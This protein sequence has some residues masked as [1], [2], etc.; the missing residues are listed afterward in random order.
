[1]FL[2]NKV[3]IK[4]FKE[5]IINLYEL[6]YNKK[7]V[8]TLNFPSK[9]KLKLNYI[10]SNNKK[11]LSL[12]I[13][14]AKEKKIYKKKDNIFG[15]FNEKLGENNIFGEIDSEEGEDDSMSIKN[16]ESESIDDEEDDY[17]FLKY[18]KPKKMKKSKSL[19]NKKITN[20]QINNIMNNNKKLNDIKNSVNINNIK[21][22]KND[23]NK[24]KEIN[25]DDLTEKEKI[26]IIHRMNTVY[27]K[28]S[29]NN[30][31]INNIYTINEN[32]IEP[33]EIILKSSKIDFTKD[34]NKNTN[35]FCNGFLLVS[36]PYNNGKI[37]ENSKNY[38]SI[39]G[40]LICSKLPA[41]ESIIIY[42][43]PLEDSKNLE[44]NNFC[45]SIC[46][47][48]GIKVC[49]N[50][51]RRSTYKSFCTNIVN[52]KGEKYYMTVYHFYHKMDTLTYNKK[53]SDNSLKNYLRKFGD[54]IYHTKEEKE[55]LEKDLEECQE[56]GFREFVYI[57]YAFALISK[58]PY[59]NQMKDILNNI[60]R[61]FTNYE[62]ILNQINIENTILNDLISY[63]IYGIPIPIPNS[64]ILFNMPF[65]SKKIRIESPYN[66]NIRNIQE[67]NY[68]NLLKYFS[69]ENILIIYR[70]MLFE[71]KILFIDKDYNRLCSIIQCFIDL[72]YPIEWV[73]TLIPMMS[74]QM[75]RYLQTFLPFING[76]SEDLLNNNALNALKEAEEG[77]YEIFIIKG[78]IELSKDNEDIY[79]GIPKLPEEV[80][81]KLYKELCDLKDLYNKLNKNEIE[82]YS[83]NINHIF[84][85]I[86]LESCS[87]MLYDFMDF[88]FN[89]EN[90]YTIFDFDTIIHSKKEKYEEFYKE[91]SDTQN[92]QNFI[93][94][95]IYNKN[96]F[97]LFINTIKNVQEKYIIN[98]DRYKGVKW[99]NCL[100]RKITLK[101]IQNKT[102]LFYLPNHLIK[103]S[104][105]N[106]IKNIFIINKDSWEKINN[107]KNNNENIINNKFISESN[108]IANYI[109]E[110]N[111]DLY[112][113]KNEIERFILPIE[114]NKE[115][116]DEIEKPIKTINIKNNNNLNKYILR[117]GF[118]LNEEE[119]EKMKENLKNTILSLL[120]NEENV[121]I[122][123]CLTYVYYNT[124]RNILIKLIYKKG[125]KV[126]KKIKEECFMSL[127]K[128]CLNAL[129][130]ICNINENEETLDFA[131]KLTQAAFCFCKENDDNL[132]LV[133]ELR[134]KLGKDYFMWIKLSFWNTWQNI[135]NYFSINEYKSYC[136]VLKYDF[137][138]KLLRLKIDKE[139]IINYLKYSLEEK[140]NLLLNDEKTYDDLIKKYNEIYND[141]KNDLM[142]IIGEEKY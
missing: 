20:L 35:S 32:K 9:T 121:S 109:S 111:N 110:I 81:K 53:Y 36:F 113:S 75:T 125:F 112:K 23:I 83:D 118:N 16:S 135:E 34:Q 130:A 82:I 70:L 93:Q 140:M 87:I 132:F 94:N 103:S 59:I 116:K 49:Y 114:I 102:A 78:T 39:C 1:M 41:M 12:F 68:G 115:Y 104:L 33:K 69:V 89:I 74:E 8:L 66:N 141:T 44:L 2:T 51:D 40:H 56:L 88:I 86:F 99:K 92:F 15:F 137:V 79:S 97:A 3:K 76:I 127:T 85:N 27:V 7:Y 90:N 138:F 61:I 10:I 58:Y 5:I 62:G 124:G 26:K 22:I 129:I 72:L 122:E 38:R 37:I 106:T 71:Q 107:N 18:K 126:V 57:P 60:F 63:L 52:H 139:F 98:N 73:N 84:K 91:L 119:K 4:R 120:K 25:K 96:S 100:E 50:Q 47:P 42:K 105:D 46:F 6:L 19:Y 55:K 14:E 64:C 13:K 43:Y 21:N 134:N 131:V 142:Q 67:I 95:M 136:D 123:N 17:F 65:N 48:T 28:R 80:H 31:I 117:N 133:D 54:N 101:D 45:A 77:V 11:D 128:I 29:Y 30:N 24:K 108:R